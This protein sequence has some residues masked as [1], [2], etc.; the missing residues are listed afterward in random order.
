MEGDVDA[1]LDNAHVSVQRF[2][3]WT[4]HRMEYLPIGPS[5]VPDVQIEFR[6]ATQ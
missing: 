3:A 4:F 2:H 6:K 1:A 5:G